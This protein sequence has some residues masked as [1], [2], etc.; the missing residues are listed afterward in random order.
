LFADYGLGDERW[1]AGIWAIRLFYICL[2][3]ASLIL[4]LTLVFIIVTCCQCCAVQ[5]S[6]KK[7]SDI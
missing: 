7:Y 3:V 5:R 2:G 1:W 4:L 6:L